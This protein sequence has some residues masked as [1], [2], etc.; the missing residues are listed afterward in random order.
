MIDWDVLTEIAEKHKGESIF[1]FGFT[2]IIWSV[3][4]KQ[5]QNK[6]KDFILPLLILKKFQFFI[7][8]AGRS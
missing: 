5:F 8:A 3:F 1:G 4:I 6:P 7:V 2:Y